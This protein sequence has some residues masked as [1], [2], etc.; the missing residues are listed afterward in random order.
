MDKL[1]AYGIG[2]GGGSSVPIQVGTWEVSMTI[3]VVFEIE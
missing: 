3:G 1:N 2:G